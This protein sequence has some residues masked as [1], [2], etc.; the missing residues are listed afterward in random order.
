[1]IAKRNSNPGGLSTASRP[2]AYRFDRP[3]TGTAKRSLPE[4]ITTFAVEH[5][6]VVIT[7]AFLAGVLL[8]WMVKRR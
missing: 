6:V 8:G 7:A 5:P 3:A 2:A 4:E 1:M